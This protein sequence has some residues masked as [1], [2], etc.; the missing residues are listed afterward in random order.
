M[1]SR[2]LV[3]A[4][5]GLTLITLLA[6]G[7]SATPAT[8]PTAEKEETVA[9]SD[10]KLVLYSGRDED[11][12]GPLIEQFTAETGIEVEVRYGKTPEISALLQEEGQRTPAE[13]F[14]SQDAGALGALA[15]AGLASELPEE[16]TG[17]VQPGFTSTDGTWVGLTGRARVIAYDSEQFTEEQIPDSVG[18][19]VDP[20]WRGKLVVV[21]GN[22]S[23][24]AFMTAFR[25]L[26]GEEAAAAWAAGI[27]ANDPIF[28]EK[29][30]A[31]L[32]LVNTGAA[33]LALINDYYWNEAAAEIGADN[34]RA[35]IKYLPGDPG[36]IV[37]VSGAAILAGAE[38]D[39]DA[40]AFLEYLVSEEGQKY[41]VENT[42]EYPLVPGVA[43]PEGVPALDSLVNEDLDLSDLESLD[44]T[45]KM[46]AEQGLL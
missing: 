26:E 36:G 27:T 5:A 4:F 3:P 16:I 2:K 19:L 13:V 44:Q 25:V 11:L 41:F 32:E 42:F 38:G 17:A 29:N 33:P 15:T 39:P 12:I 23:F 18:A 37:N 7:C 45:Q 22:A 24:Q 8:E 1:R 43:A 20:Q 6:A 14:L 35:Q 46:L 21:P 9:T 30:S 31:A 28:A 10:G 40:L 34:M